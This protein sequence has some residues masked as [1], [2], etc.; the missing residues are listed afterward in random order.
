M[1]DLLVETKLVIPSSIPLPAELASAV[2]AYVESAEDQFE[3]VNA[4]RT[5]IHG[6]SPN[7]AQPV[8]FVRWVPI[9]MVVENSYNPNSV[10][11]IEMQ[12]LL[13]SIDHDNYT[14][15][16][17]TIWDDDLQ[18][19]VV[20]DGFHRYYVMKTTPEIRERCHGRLPVV[21]LNKNINERMAA[22]VRHNRARGK[23]SVDGMS[24]MVFKMLDNGMSDVQV[25]QEL[26][27]E[28]EELLRL[29]HI[30]GFSKLFADREYNKAWVLRNQV[31]IMQRYKKQA[32]AA[33]AAAGEPTASSAAPESGAVGGE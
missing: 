18:K 28:P 15:P 21:V 29:K 3:A 8:D 9:G 11:K 7:A 10:A 30:T 17:V 1:C 31:E 4:L 13:R 23:H 20:V 25:C 22:T 24:S 32:A 16:I 5:A 27:L 33:A 14:Q 2:R 12:L 26:G 19:F 6:C